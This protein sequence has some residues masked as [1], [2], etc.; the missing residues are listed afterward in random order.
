M[1]NDCV[2]AAPNPCSKSNGGCHI[3]RKCMSASGK[4]KCGDC[5]KGMTNDGAKGC[6]KVSAGGV[7]YQSLSVFSK[8]C[9]SG[10]DASFALDGKQI[11]VPDKRGLNVMYFKKNSAGKHVQAGFKSFDTY[12]SSGATASMVKYI[13]S[14]PFGAVVAVGAQDSAE[15]KMTADGYK[16]LRMIGGSGSTLKFQ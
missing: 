5:P 14:I 4:V 13:K 7:C 1:A 2:C 11:S 3:A 12:G 9:C 10:H 6:K 8:G 16:A 15:N